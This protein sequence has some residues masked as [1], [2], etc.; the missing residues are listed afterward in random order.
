MNIIFKSKELHLQN[1]WIIGNLSVA[2][3]LISSFINIFN[4]I[5]VLAGEDFFS[6]PKTIVFNYWIF[7]H[8]NMSRSF[9]EEAMTMTKNRKVGSKASEKHQFLDI[10]I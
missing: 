6:Q 1:Y 7:I 2:D 8:Q 3:L 9:D 4:I 5:G 10:F